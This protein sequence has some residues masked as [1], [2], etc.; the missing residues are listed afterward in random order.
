MAKDFGRNNP[1]LSKLIEFLRGNLGNP[2]LL[3]SFDEAGNKNIKAFR[4]LQKRQVIGQTNPFGN[5]DLKIK[6]KG[7]CLEFLRGET[8]AWVKSAKSDRVILPRAMTDWAVGKT[9]EYLGFNERKTKRFFAFYVGAAMKSFM[10][11]MRIPKFP[12]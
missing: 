12:M 11:R 4:I 1:N 2:I 10:R 3:V 7:V 5:S 9:D 6:T 8:A